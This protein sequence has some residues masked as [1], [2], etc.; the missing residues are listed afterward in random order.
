MHEQAGLRRLGQ[1]AVD[2]IRT[3]ADVFEEQHRP[4][5]RIELPGRAHRRHQLRERAANQRPPDRS[6][7]KR[8]ELSGRQI[9]GRLA[10]H[11]HL[12]KRVL[13]VGGGPLRNTAVDHRSMDRRQAVPAIQGENGGDVAVANQRLAAVDQNVR[14]EKRQ[15]LGASVAAAH[16]NQRGDRIV[17]P[18]LHDLPDAR[19]DGARHE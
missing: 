3:L 11:H 13:I 8:L 16:R 17:L 15:E 19:L 7:V 12:A 4:V 18:R 9:A 14:I 5:R 2:A 1:H 10:R 6:P